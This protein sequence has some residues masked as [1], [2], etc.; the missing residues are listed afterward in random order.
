MTINEMNVRTKSISTKL[1]AVANRDK[2]VVL[3]PLIID[4]IKGARHVRITLPLDDQDPEMG[5]R[6]KSNCSK[7]EIG[8]CIRTDCG[9]H[10]ALRSP[11]LAGDVLAVKEEWRTFVSLDEVPSDSVWAPEMERGAGIA[12]IDGTGLSVTKSEPR[13][14]SFGDREDMSPFGKLRPAD[15]M[16][17]WA[18]RMSIE[19]T[20]VSIIR[21]QKISDSAA[22]A[23]GVVWSDRWCGFVVPG[24]EHPNP[25][26]PV[27]SR[28][29]I[30][31]MYSA[32]W[33]VLYGSGAWG[34]NPWVVSFMATVIRREEL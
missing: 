8:L 25:D 13:H 24:V 4:R 1:Y 15:E 29:T 23:E 20:S 21:L 26:F 27:L 28:A 17:S 7:Y 16:P 2:A 6:C 33:D 19:I 14:T 3:P 22:A 12:Y 5:R 34:E 31:E 18:S 10:N 11:F 9:K 32:Y 30:R